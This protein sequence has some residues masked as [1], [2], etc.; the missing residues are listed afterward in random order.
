[1][2]G[3]HKRKVQRAKQAQL[4]AAK[5]AKEEKIAIRK[6]V[7]SPCQLCFSIQPGLMDRC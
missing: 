5:K 7:C 1:M 2:T 3:F 4:E 6:Q